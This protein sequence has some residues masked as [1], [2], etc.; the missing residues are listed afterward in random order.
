MA[1]TVAAPARAHTTTAIARPRCS[2]LISGLT[3]SPDFEPTHASVTI[4]SPRRVLKLEL[5]LLQ[6]RTYVRP[7]Q[8]HERE[9]C[10]KEHR[11]EH[12]ESAINALRRPRKTIALYAATAT[13]SDSLNRPVHDAMRVP[14]TPSRIARRLLFIDGRCV[15]KFVG[16][17]VNSPAAEPSPRPSRPW[18][19]TQ[20]A[21]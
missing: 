1:P 14:R 10:G 7:Q 11:T 5:R 6:P 13:I 8:P 21:A 18:H 19:C 20:L 3:R 16:A 2:D 4:I 15:R 9:H 12:D 17:M